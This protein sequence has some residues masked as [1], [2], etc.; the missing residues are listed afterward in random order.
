MNQE[1]MGLFIAKLRKE[2][3][4]S[5]YDLAEVIPI[6]RDA[7]SKWERGKRCPEPDCLIK[8]S[9]IFNVSI[10]ELLFGEKAT[11][12]NNDI[13]NEVSIKLYEERNK[14]QKAL[15]SLV[16]V[17]LLLIFS[18]LIYYFI[19]TY[20]SL[21]VYHIYYESEDIKIPDGV[22][23]MTNEKIYFN[24]GGI[25]STSDIKYIELFYKDK[26]KVDNLIIKTD[27]SDIILADFK[28][29][30]A[31]FDFKEVKSIVKNLYLKITMNGSEKTVKLNYDKNF[32]NDYFIPKED[33]S[34]VNDDIGYDIDLETIEKKIKNSFFCNDSFCIND[35]NDYEMIYIL[36]ARTLT[37][38]YEAD[39]KIEWIYNFKN[40]NLIYQEYNKNKLITKYI[41]DKNNVS[42]EIG[43]CK[44]YVE[45]KKFF[46]EIIK[47]I[48]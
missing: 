19:N 27:S 15:K 12:N 21:K 30:N 20:N 1:K 17:I 48:N 2:K 46:N 10:N 29:Y 40:N 11:D 3:N 24:L 35:N 37:V 5:Q 13:V 38:S 41:Y 45:Q 28:G 18:F 4:M 26:N 7:V 43:N 25:T 16:G 8:L 42:C 23:V 32:S 47:S 22:L 44:N 33:K 14:K 34:S 31:Y 36:N 9:E 39:V 6:S